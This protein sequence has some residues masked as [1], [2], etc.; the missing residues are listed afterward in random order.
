MADRGDLW[1]RRWSRGE[2]SL[3]WGSDQSIADSKSGVKLEANPP[4][5][6]RFDAGLGGHGGSPRILC[7]AQL[8]YRSQPG[9][10]RKRSG[11]R[12]FPEHRLLGDIRQGGGVLQ[13]RPGCDWC[14]RDRPDE[15]PDAMICSSEWTFCRACA[16]GRLGGRC[17][18]CGGELVGR[19]SR[20]A[21]R[22]TRYPASTQR[23]FKPGGCR[24]VA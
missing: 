7:A 11:V 19:P 4:R 15:S 3:A 10:H 18:N 23:V 21:D 5:D 14:D 2:P 20:L 8:R 24:H 22:L 12:A 6:I 13:L 17:L 9:T 1:T 16:E